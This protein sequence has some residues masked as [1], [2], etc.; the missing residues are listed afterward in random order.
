MISIRQVAAAGMLIAFLA[1]CGSEQGTET[2]E[3]IQSNGGK[4][5]VDTSILDAKD[6]GSVDLPRP[7]WL[8][9]DFPLPADAHIFTTVNNDKQTPPIY[10]IQ[11]R[12]RASG[13]EVADAA[14]KWGLE[15]SV[16]NL[17][18]KQPPVCRFRKSQMA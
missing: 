12:T 6:L 11:A 4:D 15:T 7:A 8:P 18:P 10:M 3:V 16:K 5:Q 17:R 14:V 13:D 9:A 1:G 2:S